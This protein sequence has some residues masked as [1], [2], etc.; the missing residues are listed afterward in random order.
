ML[1]EA[2]VFQNGQSQAV[3]LPKEYRTTAKTFFINRV[4][5]C[6]MLIPK[7]QPWNS[8]IN[9]CAKFSDDFMTSRDQGVPQNREAFD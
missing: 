8:L 7:H 4:G 5:D 3:R 6:I 1:K 9:A 2:K